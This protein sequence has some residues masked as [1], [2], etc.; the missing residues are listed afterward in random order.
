M[1]KY[2]EVRSPTLVSHANALTD[3]DDH[4]GEVPST[5]CTYPVCRPS[6][7]RFPNKPEQ[8][9]HETEHQYKHG[10]AAGSFLERRACGAGWKAV[11]WTNPITQVEI[12][13]Y[14]IP[15]PPRPKPGAPRPKPPSGG[16]FPSSRRSARPFSQ[17]AGT[18]ERRGTS[19][20]RSSATR[21]GSMTRQRTSGEP[22]ERFVHIGS[23]EE[24]HPDG[25][26][27]AEVA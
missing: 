24:L 27:D 25:D 20:P 26:T 12:K 19:R 11:D 4:G 15:L 6:A 18:S 3:V 21:S 16:Y 1:L 7:T 17:A 9:D 13:V 22:T 23:D 5:P 10:N 14:V 2:L 8:C